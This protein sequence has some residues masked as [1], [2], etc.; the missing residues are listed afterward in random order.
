[1]CVCFDNSVKYRLTLLDSN[2]VKFIDQ[3]LSRVPKSVL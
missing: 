1:M 2:Y 3:Y